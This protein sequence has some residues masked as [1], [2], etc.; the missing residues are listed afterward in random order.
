MKT[1]DQLAA[2]VRRLTVEI[3]K[4][5]AVINDAQELRY[6]ACLSRSQRIDEAFLRLPV[7]NARK[8]W[9][10]L[11]GIALSSAIRCRQMSRSKD[12]RAWLE[13]RTSEIRKGQR[14]YRERQKSKLAESNTFPGA[15]AIMVQSLDQQTPTE[16][17]A[18]PSVHEADVISLVE[19]LKEGLER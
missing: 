9:C 16:F 2:E 14:Q 13:H 6:Q 10:E 7:E 8:V 12:T 11:A 5:N 17:M 1:L 15:F 3:I 4:V 18:Y 19:F